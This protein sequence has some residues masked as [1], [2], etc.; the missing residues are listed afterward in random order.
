MSIF[1]I[2]FLQENVGQV[3]T[4]GSTIESQLVGWADTPTGVPSTETTSFVFT[5]VYNNFPGCNNYFAEMDPAWSGT[6]FNVDSGTAFCSRVFTNISNNPSTLDFS[7]TAEPIDFPDSS[8]DAASVIKFGIPGSVTASSIS[9]T[10]Q[11]ITIPNTFTGTRYLLSFVSIYN[12]QNTG[13]VDLTRYDD[14]NNLPVWTPGTGTL[15]GQSYDEGFVFSRYRGMFQAV[16]Y[17]LVSPNE[18]VNLGTFSGGAGFISGRTWAAYLFDDEYN[19]YEPTCENK[20]D[21]QKVTSYTNNL[22][23]TDVEC[24]KATSNNTSNILQ[25]YN[26]K[27]SAFVTLNETTTTSFDV[28]GTWENQESRK[29]I[30]NNSPNYLKDEHEDEETAVE[31]TNIC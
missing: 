27:T 24:Y 20:L 4:G 29:N 14:P 10:S 11:T 19:I 16:S 6:T 28:I 1:P 22:F 25:S 17:Q 5:S 13:S 26:A 2:S 7:V 23:P 31:E 21:K 8:P 15:I 18:V 30:F 3:L 12:V 9:A